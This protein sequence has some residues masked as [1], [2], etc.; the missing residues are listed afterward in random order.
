MQGQNSSG[1]GPR[2]KKV[3]AKGGEG[4]SA[5]RVSAK[6]VYFSRAARLGRGGATCWRLL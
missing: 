3:T 2:R 6:D 5:S 4:A 1:S